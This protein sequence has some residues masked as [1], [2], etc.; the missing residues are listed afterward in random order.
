MTTRPFSTKAALSYGW[1]KM[2][3]HL[4]I[5]LPLCLISW[6]L[7]ALQ[8]GINRWHGAATLMR[9]LIAP[10]LFLATVQI[11]IVWV[12]AILRVQDDRAPTTTEL[13]HIDLAELFQYM[14][15]SLLYGLVV[16]VGMVL[17]VVPGVLWAIKYCF[18][19]F[20]IV[21][22]GLDPLTAMRRSAE[23]TRPVRGQLFMFGL[24]LLGVNILGALVL[25]VGLLATV[26][27]TMLALGQV[28][29][30]L[31]H[32][33]DATHAARGEHSSPVLA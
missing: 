6:V 29:R 14:L 16:A 23:L 20:L 15:G 10:V 4:N 26:P 21:D 11:S 7:S 27:M 9:W 1:A 12:R 24:T 33:A 17:L 3:D 22:R 32:G 8:A 2:I 5:F 13:T 18:T 30:Q 19:G 28:Y 25:G 31:L